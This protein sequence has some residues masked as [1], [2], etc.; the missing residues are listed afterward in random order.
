MAL[1]ALM[2]AP[3]A[4]P[5][6]R[7]RA[8]QGMEFTLDDLK[9][10]ATTLESYA[11]SG[12]P[13]YGPLSQRHLDPSRVR[14]GL[15]PGLVP[16]LLGLAG[17]A[18]APRRYR[19]VAVAASA[20]AIVLSLGPETALYRFLHEHVVLVRGIRA[21]SRFSLIPV[22]A[23]STLTGL[24]L[25]GRGRL[26]LLAL[27]FFVIESCHAP[28]RLVQAPPA[29]KTARWL[30]GGTGAIAYLPLGRDDTAVMLASAVHF[31]PLVNGDSGFIPRPYARAMDL[32]QPPL[33][34]DAVR[35][36]RAVD[37]R[38]VVADEPL[39]LPRLARFDGETIHGVPAGESAAPV[40]PGRPVATAWRRD[41]ILVDLGEPRLADR[42]AFELSDALWLAQPRLAASVDGITW[43]DIVATASLADATLSLLHDPIAGHGE[44]R[45]PPR[46][47]R[48]LLVDSRVP[49]RLGVLWVG[50]PAPAAA[51]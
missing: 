16:L 39:S 10:Y 34:E 3:L 13:L 29:S 41:G 18:V 50:S 47:A 32:L 40:V 44:L 6:L 33:S 22:L 31:R 17:L 11:A 23:L 45:F 9:I 37:V 49:A 7:M 1:A 4:Q 36:L 30:A 15:F 38:H 20:F 42:V 2:L 43:D 14:D 8:F 5:Y 25:A 46:M 51:R 19:A 24:A 35:F 12:T 27:A 48:Y 28:L 21:L 26:T